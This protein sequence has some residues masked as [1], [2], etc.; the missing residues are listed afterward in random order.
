MDHWSACRSRLLPQNG[1]REKSSISRWP[2]FKARREA[3]SSEPFASRAGVR[4]LGAWV[5][6]RDPWIVMAAGLGSGRTVSVQ[7]HWPDVFRLCDR[8]RRDSLEARLNWR[9]SRGSD[10][11][12]LVLGARLSLSAGAHGG[13]DF[14][15]I[16]GPDGC[17]VGA[18]RAVLCYLS[19]SRARFSAIFPSAAPVRFWIS[20]CVRRRF[21]RSASGGLGTGWHHVGVAP[22]FFPAAF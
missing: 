12:D 14:P 17:V 16:P 8:A 15:G 10:I 2:P 22:C 21:V 1:T 11:R 7:D 20:A 4:G 9:P 19:A 18:D 13:P 5:G 6:L 3:D